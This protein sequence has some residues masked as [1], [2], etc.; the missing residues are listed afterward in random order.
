MQKRHSS[1]VY[2]TETQFY[3]LQS[4]YYDPELG[5]FLN[6]DAYVSTG[7]GILGNNMFAYC[8][9]NPT[10][11]ADP[12]GTFWWPA[13]IPILVIPFLLTGCGAQNEDSEYP[14]KANCY[15]YA[16]GLKTDPRTGEPFK[17]K[18]DPGVFSGN[19]LKENQLYYE[20]DHLKQIMEK[21][22][23]A[24]AE[25]LGY[26][27]YE[28]TNIYDF[29]PT[30]GNWYIAI[31]YCTDPSLTDYHFWRQN[32]DGTWSHK[33]GTTPVMNVDFSGNVIYDPM[34]CDRGK[35]YIFLGYYEIGPN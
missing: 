16:L 35:Y 3:Y 17:E 28:I 2:D 9:N 1:Y 20:T 22:I 27:F 18:P 6:A 4:R 29:K 13:I 21:K 33:P 32:E 7:Q 12:E 15:A 10:N 11:Y 8:G 5:R 19:P 31:A 34:S 26:N 14:G 23:E 30:E 24:D 25:V